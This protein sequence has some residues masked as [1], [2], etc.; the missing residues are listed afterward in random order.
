MRSAS[1]NAR[2][3]KYNASSSNPYTRKNVRKP[4]ETLFSEHAVSKVGETFEVRKDARKFFPKYNKL[5]LKGEEI[6]NENFE[7]FPHWCF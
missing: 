2:R 6:K 3:R 5:R 4:P 7:F 1:R